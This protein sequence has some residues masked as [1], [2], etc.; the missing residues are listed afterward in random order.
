[1]KKFRDFITEGHGI[2]GMMSDWNDM[3]DCFEENF[4][5]HAI[6]YKIVKG[7]MKKPSEFHLEGS[8]YVI[9]FSVDDGV[10]TIFKN[11]K[12]Y[13]S[14]QSWEEYLK[15]ALLSIDIDATAIGKCK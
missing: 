13:D 4:P 11:G 1:M 15:W 3:I 9:K 7:T 12:E 2:T 8:K 5:A 6:K 14:N 10:F